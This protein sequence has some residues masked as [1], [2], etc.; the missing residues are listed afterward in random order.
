M[1]FVTQ[2]NYGQITHLNVTDSLGR[3][4]GE[5][6]FNED[7]LSVGV[8]TFYIDGFEN[9]L[10]IE[11]VDHG[12]II[13]ESD[14]KNGKLNGWVRHYTKK[15]GNLFLMEFYENDTIKYVL[16]FDKRGHLERDFFLIN[17]KHDGQYRAYKRG[18]I[19]L[20]MEEYKNNIKHG[21]TILYKKGIRDVEI[22]YENGKI[23][24]L[25]ELSYD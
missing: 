15:R 3:R 8:E 13:K 19:M 20:L 16:M 10:R 12:R 4:Q 18:N 1:F 9:G 23:V 17:K 11:Y 5:W 7:S 2:S 21:K 14:Y 6:Y 24:G 22:Y 25:E